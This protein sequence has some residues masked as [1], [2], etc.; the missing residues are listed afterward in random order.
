MRFDEDSHQSL[1][2]VIS[3]GIHLTPTGVHPAKPLVEAVKAQVSCP[4]DLRH[5]HF[6]PALSIV[7]QKWLQRPLQ[8]HRTE[9]ER[10]GER[11]N[12]NQ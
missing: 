10:K 12:A 6:C 7:K 4:R 8:H 2:I 5:W 3:I 11:E 9:R 1:G